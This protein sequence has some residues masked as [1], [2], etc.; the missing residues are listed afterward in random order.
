MECDG[1]V[2]GPAL[3]VLGWLQVPRLEQL[4]GKKVPFTLPF[5]W[6]WRRYEVRGS[7][8]HVNTFLNLNFFFFAPN[9]VYLPFQLDESMFLSSIKMNSLSFYFIKRLPKR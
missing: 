9:S 3:L 6:K 5:L 4:P 8:T 7:G 1:R 2:L